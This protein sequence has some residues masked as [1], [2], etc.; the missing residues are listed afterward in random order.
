MWDHNVA[1]AI[2]S[3]ENALTVNHEIRATVSGSM[4]GAVTESWHGM[5]MKLPVAIYVA[6]TVFV[7]VSTAGAY[8]KMI[9]FL[10]SSRFVMRD[11]CRLILS[12]KEIPSFSWKNYVVIGSCDRENSDVIFTHEIM[13]V[14]FLHSL[15]M[16]VFS[17][18]SILYW[19]NP[20]VWIVRKELKQLH[21]YEADDAVLEE[22]IDAV[23]YQLLLVRKAV[24]TERFMMAENFNRSKLQN[25]ITMMFRKKSK[26]YMKFAYLLCLPLI[27][28][29]MCVFA[30]PKNSFSADEII[31]EITV[32]VVSTD[33]KYSRTFRDFSLRELNSAIDSSGY[34]KDAIS[35]EISGTPYASEDI[36]N[37]VLA[38]LHNEK[39]EEFANWMADNLVYPESCKKAGIQGNVIVSFTISLTGKVCNVNILHSASPD[40]DKESVRVISGSPSWNPGKQSGS[41]VRI[42]MTMPVFFQLR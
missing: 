32:N 23:Q 1:S 20:I 12:D 31:K 27:F 6:G 22:G 5:L 42:A 33:G 34:A 41:P 18:I 28:G 40:L 24:G 29:A 36:G 17:L 2:H 21:E 11:G 19:F 8:L 39:M 15:D 25:R 26:K 4:S 13:H 30:R 3:I 16:A 37:Q 10:H 7:L 14:K 35:A 38:Y 9:M